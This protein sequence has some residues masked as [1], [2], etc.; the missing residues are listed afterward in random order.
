MDGVIAFHL[1]FYLTVSALMHLGKIVTSLSLQ[2]GSL[3]GASLYR[4]CVS[5]AFV[6]RDGFDVDLSHLFFQ[7]VLAALSLLGGV[8]GA[9]G[10]RASA[11]CE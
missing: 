3:S 7:D 5:S 10:T 6:G 9:G 11:D 1:S 8:A 4:R 2:R